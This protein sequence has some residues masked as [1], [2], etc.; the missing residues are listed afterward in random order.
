[1]SCI[2]CWE[3][4]NVNSL[5]CFPTH[6]LCRDCFRICEQ[7]NPVCPLCN[8]PFYEERD[9][10][11]HPY[12]LWR[13]LFVS[14]LNLCVSLEYREEMLKHIKKAFNSE[15]DFF[16]VNS[17]FITFQI[18]YITSIRERRIVVANILWIFVSFVLF[19]FIFA[20]ATMIV[21]SLE[22]M[23]VFVLISV[24]LSINNAMRLIIDVH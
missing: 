19:V 16:T 8:T 2:I 18:L 11:E 23:S 15:V 10:L 20:S 7:H 22:H 6:T 14:I 12:Y 9:V 13:C 3:E 24:L 4:E 5:R 1:M 17:I 21:A